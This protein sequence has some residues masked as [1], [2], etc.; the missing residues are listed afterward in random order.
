MRFVIYLINEYCIVLYR[1]TLAVYKSTSPNKLA[2]AITI[3]Q[4]A[5][6]DIDTVNISKCVKIYQHEIVTSYRCALTVAASVQAG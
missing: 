4:A 2:E 5:A 1:K 3:I 6:V